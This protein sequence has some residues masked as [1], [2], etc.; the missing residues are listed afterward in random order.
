MTRQELT[1]MAGYYDVVAKVDGTVK[2]KAKSLA[3]GSMSEEEFSAVYS[4]VIDVGLR[5]LPYSMSADQLDN[6]VNE[7]IRGFA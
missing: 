2:A 5:V 1:I 4:A 3:F 7:L 6:A